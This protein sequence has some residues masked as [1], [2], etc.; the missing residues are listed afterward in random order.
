MKDYLEHKTCRIKA[1][2]PIFI[3]NGDTIG[4]KEYMISPDGKV[5]IPDVIKMY[6]A[7]QKKHLEKQYEK[8]MLR[9]NE[10][11]GT[12]LERY[13]IFPEEYI[14]WKKYELDAGDAFTT[15]KNSKENKVKQI[16]CFVKDAYGNPYVPGSSIKGMIRTALLAY[17]I[18]EHPDTY[19]AIKKEIE[20]NAGMRAKRES[21]LSR[22]TTSLETQAFHTL[23]REKR[24]I[25][26]AVNSCL[27]GLIVSDS[28]PL[29]TDQLILCQKIDYTIQRE[30]KPFPLLREAL[31]PGTEIDFQIT[32]D[33]TVCPYTMDMIIKALNRFGEICYDSFYSR[34]QRGTTEENVVWLGGGVGFLSKTILYPMFGRKAVKVTDQVFKN[35]LGKNYKIHKHYRDLELRIAPHMCK[36]TRYQKKLYDMGMGKIE[37]L[38]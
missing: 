18:T 19:E 16:Q 3:G 37:V 10:E 6:Q 14:A 20:K 2:S 9:Y 36:C 4:K 28:N 35:T 21:Y 29:S 1:L 27:S 8:Y 5:V 15:L 32:I 38:S 25:E 13:H 17:E 31:K 22:E 7:L 26:N 30:E 34:F 12:W 24:K 11:L 23:E 33:K